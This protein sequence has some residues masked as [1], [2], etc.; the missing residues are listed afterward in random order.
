MLARFRAD[1][2]KVRVSVRHNGSSFLV[3]V[4]TIAKP[5][6]FL[7]VRRDTYEEAMTEALKSAEDLFPGI[8]PDMQWTYEHPWKKGS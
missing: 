1:P 8:D 7:F 4:R 6:E 3:T 5:S 2:S